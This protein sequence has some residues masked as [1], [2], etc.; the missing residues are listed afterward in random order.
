MP[1]LLDTKLLIPNDLWEMATQRCP[2][3]VSTEV[4]QD[5]LY[6]PSVS[7]KLKLRTHDGEPYSLIY[8]ARTV[9]DG[10]TT[11]AYEKINLRSCSSSMLFVLG[12]LQPTRQVSKIRK[13]AK[14][15]ATTVNFDSING[16]GCCVEIEIATEADKSSRDQ[17]KLDLEHLLKILGLDVAS[18]VHASNYDLVKVSENIRRLRETEG[19]RLILD[20]SS[21]PSDTQKKHVDVFCTRDFK[22]RPKF[23]KLATE[24]QAIKASVSDNL[25]YWSHRDDIVVY[26][27]LKADFRNDEEN[28]I[29]HVPR[30]IADLGFSNLYSDLGG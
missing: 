16:V 11:T 15:G 25:L 18:V 21:T 30:H 27:T 6:F 20:T 3:P 22:N 19:K 4:I 10:Q 29:V 17:K 9:E 7:G 13:T 5:D 26:A 1:L 28:I 24:D 8:Y 14:R 23:C 12:K 2:W